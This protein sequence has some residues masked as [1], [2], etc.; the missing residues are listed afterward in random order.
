MVIGELNI[1]VL[2][3][4][5]FIIDPK[6]IVKDNLPLHLQFMKEGYMIIKIGDKIEIRRR[7]NEIP[8]DGIIESISISTNAQ[9]DPAGERGA[10]VEELD[11][12]LNYS[13]S[14]GYKD[15]TFDNDNGD[16]WCYFGQ[17]IDPKGKNKKQWWEDREVINHL[18]GS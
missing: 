11:L 13:G 9:S 14:I 1:G 4:L 12:D 17:I 16:Y 5:V 7:G 18:G 8:R 2:V 15:V 6:H 3:F 10:K